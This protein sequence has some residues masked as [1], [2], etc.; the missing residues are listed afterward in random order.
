MN[1]PTAPTFA[2]GAAPRVTPADIDAAITG[3]TYTVLP[4]GRTTVCQLTLDNGFTVEGISA[5]VF[6]ENFDAAKGRAAA[7]NDAV[8]KCW[9]LLGFRLREKYFGAGVAQP[10]DAVSPPSEVAPIVNYRDGM[11]QTRASLE[12]FGPDAW[13]IANLQL[14]GNFPE[15]LNDVE[16][17]RVYCNTHCNADGSLVGSTAPPALFPQ[18]GTPERDELF[19]RCNGTSMVYDVRAAGGVPPFGQFMLDR[20]APLGRVLGIEGDGRGKSLIACRAQSWPDFDAWCRYS[21]A[22]RRR[23]GL[24]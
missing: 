13:F 15:K 7:R 17:A 20:K 2:A 24:G 3:E 23:I 22:E 11:F 18:G 16:K 6:G 8:S 10:G 4:N 9:L 19:A 21:G 14:S 12:E 1:P 5:A